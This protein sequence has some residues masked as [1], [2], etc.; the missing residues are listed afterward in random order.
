LLVASYDTQYVTNGPTI[1]LIMNETASL[2]MGYISDIN[3]TFQEDYPNSQ[4]IFYYPQTWGELEN[5]TVV[6]F[7]DGILGNGTK[8]FIDLTCANHSNYVSFGLDIHWELGGP[9]E[10]THTLNVNME[11]TYNNGSCYN[12][13]VQPFQLNFGPENNTTPETATEI[14]PGNVY[15]YMYLS[16]NGPDNYYKTTAEAGQTIRVYT[17][18]TS[19]PAP[20]AYVQ[21]LDANGNLLTQSDPHYPSSGP[22]EYT[23]NSTGYFYIKLYSIGDY[24]F[25]SIKIEE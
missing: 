2:S 3:A 23:A 19:F 20:F 13:I 22:L 8:A 12:K 17:T 6:S 7:T 1:T 14:E 18:Y 4:I 25:Y 10:R 11:T 5:V 16:N 15:E 9:Q 24:G 21:I